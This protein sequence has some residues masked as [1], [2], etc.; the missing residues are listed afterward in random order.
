[1]VLCFLI[2]AAAIALD[3]ITKLLVMQNI[4]KGASVEVIR[5]VFH[6]TYTENRGAAFGMLSQHRWI[7]ML[8]SAVAIV[9]IFLYLWKEKPKSTLMRLSLGM[10][11]GGGIGNMIDRVIRGF[12]VDFIDIKF[13]PLWNYIFNVADIFVCVGC[14]LLILY[15]IRAEIQEHRRKKADLQKEPSHRQAGEDT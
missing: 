9:A 5:G 15:L 14:G 11:L 8:L 1:M 6:L 13:I 12:V 3:Q 10:I 4:G 7:F 2:A